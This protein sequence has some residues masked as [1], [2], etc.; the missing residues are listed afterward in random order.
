MQGFLEFQKAEKQMTA[1]PIVD[2][3]QRICDATIMHVILHLR[4]NELKAER[5]PHAVVARI[6]GMDSTVERPPERP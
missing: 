4:L 5:P 1:K 2:Y 3:F 6:H